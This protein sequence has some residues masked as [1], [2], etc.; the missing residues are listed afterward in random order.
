MKK[1]AYLID[2]ISVL[3]FVTI[4]RHTHKDGNTVSGTFTTL[5]PF[6]VGLLIGWLLVSRTHR[7][8]TKKTSGLIIALSAVLVGMILRVISG[9]GIALAFVIVA[10]A[11]LSFCLVGWRA[12]LS[13]RK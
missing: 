7:I 11:F 13:I 9:Q 6:A 12:L 2:F 1:S 3:V 5:W 8:A 4:G 10:T